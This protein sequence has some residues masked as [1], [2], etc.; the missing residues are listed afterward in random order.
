[1]P[2]PQFHA[3]LHIHSKYSRACSRDCDLE[4][5]T[6]FAKR[7]G[8]TLVGTGDF[9][10]PAWNAHLH[11]TLVEAEPGLYRLNDDLARSV[12][13][14]LPGIVAAST[15]RFMLSVEISTIYKRDDK[16][17]KVHHLV[18]LPDL[19]AVARFNA[20]LA[21]IGNIASDGRPILGLD[22]RDLL[23]ITLEASPDGYL[24]PAHIWT[25]WFAALGSKSGFDAI[26]DCYADLA[27]HVFAVETGLSSDPAMNWRV[28]SLDRYTLVSNSDAHSPP[29]LAREAHSYDCELDYFAV[30]EALRT[31][32]GYAGSIEFFPEEGKYHAD[33]HRACNL[34]WQP[35]ETIAAGGKCEVCGKPV[36]VG[37]LSRVEA[38]ADRADGDRPPGKANF[39]N[40]VPLPE[41]VGEINSVGPRSK[42]VTREIDG[43]VA[44]LGAELGI[45]TE[46]PVDQ[47]A[48]VGGERLGEAI[49]RLRRGEV[50]RRSG[51]DGEYGVIRLFEPSELKAS[52]GTSALF[53]LPSQ[54]DH[55][56]RRTT[57]AQV[58]RAAN[59]E[60]PGTAV[61]AVSGSAPAGAAAA[62]NG[63]GPIPAAATARGRATARGKG[64]SAVGRTADPAA[65]VETAAIP[66]PRGGA[67][68][69][70]AA[71]GG[72]AAGGARATARGEQ[73]VTGLATHGGASYGGAPG[74]RADEP[75]AGDHAGVDILPFEVPDWGV[76]EGLDPEQRAAAGASDGPLIVVA[77]P[78]TGKT[79][80][81]THRVAYL[82]AERGVAA[83][84]CLAIT[85][86]RRAAGELA[87]RLDSLLP[88]GSGSPFVATFHALALTICRE[89]FAELGFDAPPSVADE[90][91]VSA[92]L[93]ELDLAP[94]SAVPDA[95]SEGYRKRL[96]ARGLLELDELVPLAVPFAA[97]Y[98]SRW[99][100]VLVDEYQDVDASQYAL[101]R[102]LVPSDGNLFAIGDPDQSIYS[103]RGAEVGFFLRFADDFPAATT[104]TLTRNYRSAPPIVATAVQVVRPGTL[105]PGRGLS[106]ERR[107][108]GA[109]RIAVHA[110]PTE[111]SEAGWVAA[112]VD[113]LVGGSS[114]HSLDSGR[115][116]GDEVEEHYDFGDVAVLYRSAAQSRA[117]QSAFTS[118]GLPFQKRGV[119]RLADR[120]AVPSMLREMALL[121]GPVPARLQAAGSALAS[122]A[123]EPDLFSDDSSLRASDVWAAVELLRPV[124]SSFEDDL[125]GFLAYVA[126]GAEV[127]ALD[128]RAD[129]VSLLTLHAAK[130]LEFPVV[131]IV[132]CV[133][134]V[135]PLVFPGEASVDE[136]LA[137]ERRLFFVG[138]TR[139]QRRL[140]LSAPRTVTRRGKSAPAT[141]TPFLAPVDEGLLDRTGTSEES[142]R[143]AARQMRLI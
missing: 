116:D 54:D 28:S 27:D 119:D 85:F 130:G 29:A 61:P 90:A 94:G 56:T 18:Y 78:G 64:S 3:D 93:A 72:A 15:V 8:L 32:D 104:V 38:L 41:I 48:A 9:T 136:R 91:D 127:D 40:L 83:E 57:A 39:R 51:Y 120:P 88:S 138:V 100:H 7:K 115:V 50:I 106:A 36:T 2:R 17:R 113:S 67:A 52:A 126:T 71:A 45:L 89:H 135:V 82:V 33:G 66:A 98:R 87:S 37:V 134:G 139:A 10:H 132:G 96:R 111:V 77:G 35:A 53:D 131:F 5:L 44:A 11:E 14:T 118:A 80:T 55:A 62:L 16:T 21:K 107:D 142:R 102:E 110:V 123:A 68:A 42:T 84:S 31:G 86:T 26:A 121:P 4:H 60:A 75:A 58:Q 124:A 46:V 122:R 92:V 43:L 117:L 63:T 101:L 73:D 109:A 79:R 49:A 99:S 69:G 125:D 30:K 76:L 74:D 143:P 13:R 70:G 19:D 105:V 137:E 103:F 114:F 20:K 140:F 65:L 12:D 1:M 112:T 24:V 22:S 97:G 81:L 47:V 108:L 129:A 95:L 133:D 25:P 23:E 59:T 34:S 6:W 141:L 128:P